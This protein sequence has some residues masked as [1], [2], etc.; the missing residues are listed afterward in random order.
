M[1]TTKTVNAVR[2]L[3]TKHVAHEEVEEG[4]IFDTP[5]DKQSKGTDILASA[6]KGPRLRKS[7]YASIAS[8]TGPKGVIEAKELDHI[9][10]PAL[11]GAR[12]LNSTTASRTGLTP[13]ARSDV[14]S[15]K[16]QSQHTY[17]ST[18]R[19][20]ALAAAIQGRTVTLSAESVASRSAARRAPNAET[21]IS[22]FSDHGERRWD[23][24]YIMEDFQF[25]TIYSVPYHEP[26]SIQDPNNPNPTHSVTSIGP[27]CSKFRKMICIEPHSHHVLGV[28]IGTHG[29]T[30]IA[31]RSNQEEYISIRDA[32]SREFSAPGESSHGV[33][34]AEHYSNFMTKGNWHRMTDKTAV[35]FTKIHT[36]SYFQKCTV[37]G[38]LIPES[39]MLLKDLVMKNLLMNLNKLTI[40]NYIPI[41]DPGYGRPFDRRLRGDRYMPARSRSRTSLAG[42]SC[43][44]SVHESRA[45]RFVAHTTTRS[46][47]LGPYHD[48]SW[49][50]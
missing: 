9:P 2:T 47:R 15:I 27:V 45:S 32:A 46:S 39:A 26:T 33:L 4:E 3:Q 36:H 18:A 49:R 6:P 1:T 23:R 44:G 31:G 11:K 40:S 5:Q 20:G 12:V 50:P 10:V 43:L 37:S 29:G 22:S 8:S 14:E 16:Y 30:G 24:S 28:V 35:C 38:Y 21:V 34:W 19:G 48:N 42:R 7:T 17:A 41:L 13:L 25:G